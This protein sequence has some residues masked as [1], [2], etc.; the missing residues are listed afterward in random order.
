MERARVVDGVI[1]LINVADN[2]VFIDHKG[3]SVGK[4]AGEAQNAVGFGYDFVGVAKQGEAGAGLFRELAI[5]LLGIK[6]DA[7]HLCAGGLKFGDI[8]L[9]S[10][11]L[12]SSTRSGSSRIKRQNHG[13]L[14][15]KIGQLHDF[16][17]LVRQ[18]KSGSTV[19]NLKIRRCTE[20][21]HK[22]DS[23]AKD[24]REF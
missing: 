6:A 1:V 18:G 21:W 8:T 3:H 12:A 24:H 4:Q 9:I 20:E 15:L 19:A 11:D 16:P 5:P 23:A 10:L 13:F 2:A 14:A 22:E 7:Q 17:I